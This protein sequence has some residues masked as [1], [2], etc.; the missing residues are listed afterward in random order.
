MDAEKIT[1]FMVALIAD[2]F[3]LAIRSGL[4]WVAFNYLVAP[5]FS[6]QRITLAASLGIYLII[7]T[8]LIKTEDK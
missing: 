6:I 3:V 1:E 7:K 8:S 5:C 2:V 4:I